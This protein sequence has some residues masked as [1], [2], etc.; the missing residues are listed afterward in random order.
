MV[1]AET[2]SVQSL[3]DLPIELFTALGR[4]IAHAGHIE[5]VF[6][7]NLKRTGQNVSWEEAHDKV[8][9]IKHRDKI[10]KE[11]KRSFNM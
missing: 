2:L 3:S 7:L 1:K 6:T 10:C 5:H 4:V 9:D 8:V 11:V